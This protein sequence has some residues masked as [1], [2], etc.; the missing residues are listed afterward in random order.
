MSNEIII[1]QAPDESEQVV[2]EHREIEQEKLLSDIGPESILHVDFM[3]S[4]TDKIAADKS[5]WVKSN[6]LSIIAKQILLYCYPIIKEIP[7]NENTA[8]PQ[9]FFI[10]VQLNYEVVGYLAGNL[11][12]KISIPSETPFR[13]VGFKLTKLLLPHLEYS[14][15]QPAHPIITDIREL[16]RSGAYSY[17]LNRRN[18]NDVAPYTQQLI[19]L[20]TENYDVIPKFKDESVQFSNKDEAKEIME[21]I[22]ERILLAKEYYIKFLPL[23]MLMKPFDKIKYIH[24]VANPINKVPNELKD[25]LFYSYANENGLK[26]TL[27]GEDL[28]VLYNKI[29]K[30][31]TSNEVIQS[32]I[33]LK[34]ADNKIK[35][36][37]ISQ[38]KDLSL[39]I[40]DDFRKQAIINRKFPGN[41]FKTLKPKE[42]EVV[43]REF[44][45]L[46]KKAKF[47]RD[48]DIRARVHAFLKSFEA[49]NTAD[50]L[51]QTYDDIKSLMKEKNVDPLDLGLC[52]HYLEHAEI[53]LRMYK[54]KSIYKSRSAFDIRELLI[55]KYTTVDTVIDDEYYCKVCG[56]LIASDD[57][58]EVAEFSGD[59]K[60]NTGNETDPLEELIYRDV[61]HIIRTFVKFKNLVDVRPIIKSMVA[62]MTSEMHVIETKLKQIQTNISDDLRDLMG[63]YIYIYAFALISHMIFVNYGQITFAFREGAFGGR[64]PLSADFYR[65]PE[66]TING[67]DPDSLIV[68]EDDNA[69]SLIVDG[70]DEN[71]G[72]SAK[73]RLQNILKNALYLINSTKIKLL[74]A[75]NNIG[76]DKVKPILLQ[77]YQWVLKLQTYKGNTVKESD[78]DFE[79]LNS[80]TSSSIYQY[81][82][83]V[84]SILHPKTKESDLKSV[85][86]IDLETIKANNYK[87]KKEKI[88]PFKS[89]HEIAEKD[90]KKTG[91]EAYDTYTYGS[92]LQSLRYEKNEAYKNFVTPL[93]EQLQSHYADAKKLLRIE[94]RLRFQSRFA[95]YGAFNVIKRTFHYT[96]ADKIKLN[97]SKYYRPDGTKRKW[98]TLVLSDDSEVDASGLLKL[99]FAKRLSLKVK[100]RKDG[101]EYLSEIKDYSKEINQ[102]FEQ[103]DFNKS[104]LEYYENRCPVGGIHEFT[105]SN[106]CTKCQ[107]D[108]DS[109]WIFTSAADHYVKT[110]TPLFNKY[111]ALKFNMAK[112]SL[113]KI[114]E[115]NK[116]YEF[117]YKEF[118]PWEY[119]EVQ[120]LEWSRL[121]PKININMLNNLGCSEHKKYLLIEKEKDNPV[122]DYSNESQLGRISKLDAYYNSII[123]DY[124]SVKNYQLSDH[125]PL[126][127]KDLIEKYKAELI[128]LPEI[129]DIDYDRKLEWYKIKH[130]NDNRLI[131]NFILVQIANIILMLS[132]TG[133]AG[134][135]LADMLSHSLIHKEKL[136]SKPD[137]FKVVIDKRTKDDEYQSDTSSDGS[138][139]DDDILIDSQPMS[140]AESD[141][142]EQ[143]QETEA[144]NF[145]LEDNAIDDVNDG[146][147]DDEEGPA[148]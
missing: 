119:S 20:V 35:K 65:E 6:I 83:T 24:G 92:Y 72:E 3:M 78:I 15:A 30:L 21:R 87:S 140:E 130:V 139:A 109:K 75:S 91:S 43:L 13:V 27:I 89:A 52:E 100:D 54:D 16:Y 26:E 57:N 98:N 118:P 135:A 19:P 141:V 86:G 50:L 44:E 144:Y 28:L 117:K 45:L 101:E 82:Y 36:K 95:I 121:N 124:Y 42:Q 31:G 33:K 125:L 104:L 10:Q 146:N 69:E 34:Q 131:C 134:K 143:N 7:S 94:R 39:K 129:Q 53:M 8:E 127:Y 12:K 68:D 47:I 99:D 116:P 128:K 63:M 32:V 90:W 81:L 120:I 38:E 29:K 64:A 123:R 126:Y 2:K 108:M 77:A 58:A 88:N 96:D 148:E 74:K 103:Q 41:K 147:D 37:R 60:L 79:I 18:V 66:P 110:H 97:I 80:I 85:I 105:G 48:K 67:G 46:N 71:A 138:I 145:E 106:I 133:A 122:K 4:M 76:P 11:T 22:L 62:S 14:S 1:F 107:R 102:K 55:S 115:L 5:F 49:V 114:K 84:T 17:E 25:V 113:S 70:G 136:L 40:V 142:N 51:Q 9:D 93:S 112:H 61:S 137:P 56:Q 73:E 132:K 111:N 23:F 59:Q